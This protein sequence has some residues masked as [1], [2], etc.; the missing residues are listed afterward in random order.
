M[1]QAPLEKF[2]AAGARL[3]DQAQQAFVD[4]TGTA[5]LVA[6][7]VLLV[8]AVYVFVRAPRRQEESAGPEVAGESAATV[9]A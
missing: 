1:Q 8:T 3:A 9:R 7:G 2:G 5:F 6:A 4:A